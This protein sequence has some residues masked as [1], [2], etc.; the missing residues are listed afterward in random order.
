MGM[1]ARMLA[2]VLVCCAV[3]SAMTLDDLVVGKT[4]HGPNLTL[5][6]MKGKVVFANFWGTK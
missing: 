3:A 1:F 2:P 4:V 5:K 6:E